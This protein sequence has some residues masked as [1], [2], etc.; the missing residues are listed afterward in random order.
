MCAH[1]YNACEQMW[2]I[3]V[4]VPLLLMASKGSS[5]GSLGVFLVP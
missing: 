4:E 3:V 1:V 5:Q 2:R